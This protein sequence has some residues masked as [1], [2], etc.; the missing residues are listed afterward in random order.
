MLE[1]TC[2]TSVGRAS[3]RLKQ[4]IDLS[5]DEVWFVW[6]LAKAWPSEIARCDP[7]PANRLTSDLAEKTPNVEVLHAVVSV[8]EV[9]SSTLT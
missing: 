5:T 2:G 1:R 8:H 4:Q 7:P 3:Y 9:Q 6:R